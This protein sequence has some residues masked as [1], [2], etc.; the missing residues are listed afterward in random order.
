MECKSGAKEHCKLSLRLADVIFKL[1]NQ[2]NSEQDVNNRAELQTLLNNAT[3]QQNQLDRQWSRV[4][5][6]HR[7]NFGS[8]CDCPLDSVDK[9]W[10]PL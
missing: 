1:Q 2:L 10:F 9:T 5:Q 8:P 6:K 3:S 7:S 4:L